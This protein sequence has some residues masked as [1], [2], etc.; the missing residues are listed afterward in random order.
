MPG[1][2]VLLLRKHM[3][4]IFVHICCAVLN[5]SVTSYS[6]RPHGLQ[7]ARLLCPWGFSR[8]EY[9]SGLSCLPPGDSPSPGIDPDLLHCRQ[10]LYQLSHQGS[11]CSHIPTYILYLHQRIPFYIPLPSSLSDQHL[12]NFQTTFQF[13]DC[14]F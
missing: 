2:L 13:F 11:P 3:M 6:L 12:L 8:Q 10:I 9:W 5:R 14:F 1:F 4:Y 7:P